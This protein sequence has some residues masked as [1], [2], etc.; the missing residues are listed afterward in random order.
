VVNLDSGYLTRL[1]EALFS[2]IVKLL[3][4]PG[5]D[6][7]YSEKAPGKPK[8]AKPVILRAHRTG[9][10]AMALFAAVML[11]VG[12]DLCSDH[13]SGNDDFDPAVLLPTCRRAVVCYGVVH[14]EA[15][16]R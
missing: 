2:T 4:Q 7:D 8:A 10:F 9:S 14:T 16:R 15:L 5:L 3:A 13:F 6:P 11:V 1:S 12:A